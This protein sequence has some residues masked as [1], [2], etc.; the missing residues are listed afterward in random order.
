MVTDV[1]Y[2][3][4]SAYASIGLYTNFV[5]QSLK[6]DL[7]DPV[8]HYQLVLEKSDD[9][10]SARDYVPSTVKAFWVAESVCSTTGKTE[11]VGAVGLDSSSHH[12]VAGTGE[13]RRIVV[14][15]YHRRL[16]IAAALMNACESR[17][18]AC[19]LSN[20]VLTTSQ[21]QPGAINMYERAG[22]RVY[23]RRAFP[24]GWGTIDLIDYGKGLA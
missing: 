12:K 24:S 7:E 5:S 23:N 15:P 19:S 1:V 11:I 22:Y 9:S 17:A 4:G 6:D 16:G 14:S 13:V 2:I 8:G 10:S 20:M 21:Y 3:C 18:K